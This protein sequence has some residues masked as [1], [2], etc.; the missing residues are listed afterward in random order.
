MEYLDVL[1]VMRRQKPNQR[2][3]NMTEIEEINKRIDILKDDFVKWRKVWLEKWMIKNAQ[4]NYNNS[5]DN[6]YLL[7]F[8]MDESLTRLQEQAK[9]EILTEVISGK[10]ARVLR[11]NIRLKE[12]PTKEE[13]KE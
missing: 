10:S 6:T 1:I 5:P 7:W 11:R 8:W 13:G 2:T 3:E 4:D 9:K 12:L